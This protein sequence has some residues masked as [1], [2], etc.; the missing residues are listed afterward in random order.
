[1]PII[2]TED[3][4][5]AGLKAKLKIEKLEFLQKETGNHEK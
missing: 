3:V 5:K 1:V 4:Q 2:Q